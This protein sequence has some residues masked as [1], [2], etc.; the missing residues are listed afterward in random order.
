MSIEIAG[1]G[2]ALKAAGSLPL[3]ATL[4]QGVQQMLAT[5]IRSAVATAAN[6]VRLELVEAIAEQ[7]FHGQV[8]VSGPAVSADGDPLYAEVLATPVITWI[9]DTHFDIEV[10]NA[11]A[12][13]ATPDLIG[14]YFLVLRLTGGIVDVTNT[15]PAPP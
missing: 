7:E 12:V 2:G 6:V 10:A 13:S 3:A 1:A 8:T 9:D 14:C 4:A 11:L 15:I 5:G